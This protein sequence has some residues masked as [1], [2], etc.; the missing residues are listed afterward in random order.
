MRRLRRWVKPSPRHVGWHFLPARAKVVY[1]PLG[2]VGI[3]MP[4]NYPVNLAV[5]P[6][7]AALAAGNRAMI[8][9]SEFTPRIAAVLGEIQGKGLPEDR[10]A[11]VTGEA[12]IA[13]A[14]SK[15][16]FDH[17]LFTGSIP[18]GRHVMCA[19]ADNLTPV[20]LEL[21]GK[22]PAIIADDI[23]LEDIIDRL[24]FAKSVNAGQTCVAPD[25]ALLP[26]SKLEKFVATRRRSGRCIR[27]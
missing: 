21:G 7:I 1:Q 10:L 6:L 11:V 4:F 3:M 15:L 24:V 13:A 16:P 17:L 22:S 12:D 26:R 23:P 19:A 27:R 25:Y 18:V 14:F 8:K 20:T 5:E 9:M 2:V